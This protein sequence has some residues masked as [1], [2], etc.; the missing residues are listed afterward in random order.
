MDN[1]FRVHVDATLGGD[2]TALGEVLLEC[3]GNSF[4]AGIHG[5]VNLQGHTLLFGSDERCA[6]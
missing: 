5:T 4:E 1:F 6:E 3:I 2:I